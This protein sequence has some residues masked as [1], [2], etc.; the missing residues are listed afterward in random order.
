MKDTT[1]LY[2]V[3]F[4]RQDNGEEDVHY[5]LTNNIALIENEYADWTSIKPLGKPEL[6]E[7]NQ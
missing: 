1:L 4:I 3:E 5:V 6:L 7:L 2:K